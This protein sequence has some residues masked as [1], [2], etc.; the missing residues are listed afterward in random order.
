MAIENLKKESQIPNNVDGLL[1]KTAEN[2]D[3]LSVVLKSE[4][5]SDWKWEGVG[6]SQEDID[7]Y[8]ENPYE[9]ANEDEDK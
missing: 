5:K 1:D 7:K 4:N 9:E 2:K 8:P 6:K 3:K